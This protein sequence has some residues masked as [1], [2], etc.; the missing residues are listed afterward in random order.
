[1]GLLSFACLLQLII[2]NFDGKVNII[3]ISIL[4]PY[5]RNLACLVI[6]EFSAR[7]CK[8]CAGDV[9]RIILFGAV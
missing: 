7:L 3:V 4:F 6:A 2:Y 5:R 8:K 9:G 1:M